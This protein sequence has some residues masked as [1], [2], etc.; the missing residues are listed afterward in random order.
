MGPFVIDLVLLTIGV[1]TSSS[2]VS[3][4][5]AIECPDTDAEHS[6]LALPPGRAPGALSMEPLRSRYESCAHTLV[7]P[8]GGS[9]FYLELH[10][11]G[12]SHIVRNI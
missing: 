12:G 6:Q 4:Q 7:H 11:V 8:W 3:P 9:A 2:L 1:F 10:L 5:F